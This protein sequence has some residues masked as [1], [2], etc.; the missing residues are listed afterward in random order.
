MEGY[1]GDMPAALFPFF[2]A[3]GWNSG[4]SLHKFQD[5]T[6]VMRGGPAGIR[7]FDGTVTNM[8]L[9]IQTTAR[10]TPN[11]AW[12]VLPQKHIF[13]SEELSARAPAV[14]ELIPPASLALNAAD[15]ATLGLQ[16]GALVELAIGEATLRLPLTLA[17]DLAS[18]TAVSAPAG[19]KPPGWQPPSQAIMRTAVEMAPS[20]ADLLNLV[21]SSA[22]CSAW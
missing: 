22:S 8:Q 3:P 2:W 14:A 12:L 11:G 16:P 15:A 21:E 4:Q 18:G 1:Y 5:E 6:G 10:A 9:S 7:L 20:C 13:G 19:R 17:P